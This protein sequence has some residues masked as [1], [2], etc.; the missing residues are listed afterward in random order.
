M[1]RRKREA[2]VAD[3][4]LLA[5]VAI[6]PGL[7]AAEESKESEDPP[8][9]PTDPIT[10]ASGA[11]GKNYLNL[12]LNGLIAAGGSSEGDVPGL[13]LGSH[14]PSRRGFT[15]QN[16]ELVFSGAVDPYFTAQ[17]SVVFV[18]TPN[19]ESEIE[20][21]EF[22]ATTSSL[23]HSLQVKVGHF[24][25]EFGRLNAQ[26]PHS[27]D[28][29]DQPLS[30]ARMFGSDNL[31]ASGARVSW[32]MPT[33]FY[34]EL[35]L[36]I[37]N[38]FGETLTSFGWAEGEQVFGSTMAAASVDDLGD[39]LYVP[40]Y[41]FS[42]DVTDNQTILAGLSSAFGPNGT[43][44]D[45]RTQLYGADLFW[46]WKSP[47]AHQGFPFVKV[48][49]ESIWRH[50]RADGAV[51]DLEDWG[52]YGQ[53]LWGFRRGWVAG[54]RFGRMGGDEGP[55][56]DPFVEERWRSAVNLTWFPTEYSKLRLQYNH[57]AR[58]DFDD[59]DSVWLQIEL[60][61]GAHAAHKF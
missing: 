33:P 50:Y 55:T 30:H 10:V 11:A 35:Y 24:F 56:P 39:L 25:T 42:V 61:L 5:A 8:A 36:T 31:R 7:T 52:A 40:R 38:A 14:D 29:V 21:E 16:V 17:A 2:A 12:S 44:P 15:L 20:L 54:A 60:I 9:K 26:H 28:F 13:Q 45:G 49:A 41:A 4:L 19:G 22:F 27:W 32:L 47:R 46:K 57:D 53:V 6:H 34:S 59:A 51:A 37:Q 43:G 48:Q 3:F 1:S 23:P 18:E 58:S